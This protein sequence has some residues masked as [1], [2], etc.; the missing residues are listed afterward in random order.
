MASL[1]PRSR[2]YVALGLAFGLAAAATVATGA[3]SDKR[4]GGASAAS[5]GANV[6]MANDILNRWQPIAVAAGQDAATWRSLFGTQLTQMD[7]GS[8]KTLSE[9]GKSPS[10][11]YATFLETFR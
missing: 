5:A 9:V 4:S 11:S 1:S 3:D 6:V 8:L 7:A 10:A 2:S